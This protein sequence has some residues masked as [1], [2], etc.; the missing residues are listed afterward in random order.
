MRGNL[1]SNR[2]CGAAEYCLY[3]LIIYITLASRPA[4]NNQRTGPNN[5][6]KPNLLIRSSSLERSLGEAPLIIMLNS[7]MHLPTDEQF[8]AHYQG[9]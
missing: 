4:I 1:A 9:V 5:R 6:N 3:L 8:P 7:R 2:R